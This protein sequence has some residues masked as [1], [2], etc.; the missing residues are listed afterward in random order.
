M[1]RCIER[2]RSNRKGNQVFLVLLI[3]H[4]AVRRPWD[5]PHSRWPRSAS[6]AAR[7]LRLARKTIQG[8]C[9]RTHQESHLL[10]ISK[11]L[12]DATLLAAESVSSSSTRK[13]LVSVTPRRRKIVRPVVATRV[14]TSSMR[15]ASGQGPTAPT[16]PSATVLGPSLRSKIGPAVVDSRRRWSVSAVTARPIVLAP[17][18]RERS[19]DRV[20]SHPDSASRPSAI[21]GRLLLWRLLLLHRRCMLSRRVGIK[22]VPLPMVREEKL[23][24]RIDLT[25][26]TR[27]KR[28][29]RD[30]RG[31]GGKEVL[32]Y[33]RALAGERREVRRVGLAGKS[34]HGGRRRAG[35]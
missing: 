17:S 26:E 2:E 3:I 27:L 12:S 31:V 7:Q 5:H 9:A 35:G 30:G 15:L 11:Q 8:R 14:H 6:S 10:G 34:G 20:V 23:I 16:V 32:V 25:P 4:R 33:N 21:N 1:E 22:S 29:I 19:L 13:S 24:D 18:I 28:L